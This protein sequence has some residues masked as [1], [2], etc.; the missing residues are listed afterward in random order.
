MVDLPF[1][2]TT[3]GCKWVYKIKT[4]V[5]GTVER[6][7]A[8]LVAQG[9]TQEYG[10]DYEDTFALVARLTYIRTLIVV[11]AVFGWS[12]FQIDV[13]NNLL[14]GN[15]QEKVYMTPSLGYDP[16]HH[17]VCCLCRALYGFKQAPQD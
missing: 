12:L 10:I 5:D 7:K 6:Y 2:K 13:K 16:P 15:S 8:Y 14:N 3:V 4:Q 1:G 9:F 17:K 11:V